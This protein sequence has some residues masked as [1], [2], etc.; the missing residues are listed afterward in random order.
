M[1]FLYEV[2]E[3]E[4]AGLLHYIHPELQY[5]ELSD[6]LITTMREKAA[7]F[8]RLLSNKHPK[9]QALKKAVTLTEEYLLRKQQGQPE[10]QLTQ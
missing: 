8:A 4:H 9:I 1:K 7:D 3:P 6:G 10:A 5:T 2:L